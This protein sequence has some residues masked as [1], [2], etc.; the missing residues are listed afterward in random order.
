MQTLGLSD[1]TPKPTSRIR[2]LFWPKIDSDIAAVTAA[3]NAMYAAFVVAAFTALPA[4]SLGGAVAIGL[5]IDVALYT[6][7]GIGVRQLSRTAALAGF[8]MYGISWIILPATALLS[9][10]TIVRVLAT[11]FLLNGVRA[12][13]FAHSTFKTDEID[14]IANPRSDAPGVSRTSIALEQAPGKIWPI[15]RAP[16]FAGLCLVVLLS[17]MNISLATFGRIWSQGVESMEK[18]ILPGDQVFAI[19]RTWMGPVRRGDVVI[20]IYP[21]DPRQAFIKRVVGLPGDRIKIVNKDLFINGAR[22]NEPYVEHVTDYVDSYR[23]N[24]PSQPNMAL[25]GEGDLMLTNFVR[26]GEVIVP[27]GNYFVLGDN[28]DQSLDSRYWGFVPDPNVIGRPVLVTVSYDGKARRTGRVMQWLP[29]T[30]M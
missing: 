6:M 8:I 17:L 24:F 4:F 16:F 9:M 18:T 3:R 26:N 14:T 1:S 25:L 20:L 21:V 2:E 19:H 10:G 7:V 11:V 28:R 23:D 5:W 12:A 15:L 22:P 30:G 29:R 27:P 13:M